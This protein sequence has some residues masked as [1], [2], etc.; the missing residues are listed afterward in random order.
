MGS[1]GLKVCHFGL[2]MGFA[3]GFI[4]FVMGVIAWQF[5]TGMSM[6]HVWASF[7]KG[8]AATFQGSLM[9]ALWGFCE[10]FVFGAVLAWAYNY[11]CSHC[12]KTA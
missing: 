2:A 5:H 9:G 10:G 11:T 8:Y 4:M 12:S 7:Y 6:V 3:W 1:K